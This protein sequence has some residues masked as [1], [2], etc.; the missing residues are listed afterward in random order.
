MFFRYSTWMGDTLRRVE[1]V[2]SR[3]GSAARWSGALQGGRRVVHVGDQPDPVLLVQRARLGR[4]VR[5]RIVQAEERVELRHLRLG[6]DLAV[7]VGVVA[8]DHHAVEPGER[9]HRL[10]GDVVQLLQRRR[11]VEVADRAADGLVGV[12][13]RERPRT[14]RRLQLDHQR[15]AAIRRPPRRRPPPRTTRCSSASTGTGDPPTSRVTSTGLRSRRSPN[16]L[17]DR[18]TAPGGAGAQHVGQRPAKRLPPGDADQVGQVLRHLAD[19]EVGVADL[20]EHAAGLDAARHVDRLPLAVAEIDR[21]ARG[22]Q[23]ERPLAVGHAGTRATAAAGRHQA[24]RAP[25]VCRAAA[26]IVAASPPA[27]T[28]VTGRAAEAVPHGAGLGPVRGERPQPQTGQLRQRGEVP[29][30]ERAAERRALQDVEPAQRLVGAGR[31]RQLGAG[32]GAGRA[33][34]REVGG[35]QARTAPARPRRRARRPPGTGRP[36]RRGRPRPPARTRASARARR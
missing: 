31:S 5:G 33:E 26:T 1:K 7:V 35:E 10:R 25:N 16:A 29:V 15:R 11:P 24:A 28:R 34:R 23:V 22:Q 27:A 8:V 36:T 6:H 18:M 12:R 19:D 20:D 13:E 9:P 21:C 3:G 4:D 14:V 17:A 30:D 32:L 2:R